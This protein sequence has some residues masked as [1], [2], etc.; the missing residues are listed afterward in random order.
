MLTT[1]ASGAGADALR[2]RTTDPPGK[3]GRTGAAGV[4][5]SLAFRPPGEPVRW[6]ADAPGCPC[7]GEPDG[8]DACPDGMTCGGIEVFSEGRPAGAVILCVRRA[9]PRLVDSCA[10]RWR[11]PWRCAGFGGGE[12]AMLQELEPPRGRAWRRSRKSRGHAPKEG[13][14]ALL[15]RI[16]GR[17]VALSGRLAGRV[18]AAA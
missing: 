14:G 5:L 3:P 10:G 17:A 6:F 18:V 15:D 11:P 7:A 8:P 9:T 13:T 12:V 2:G 16:M 4:A 1:P